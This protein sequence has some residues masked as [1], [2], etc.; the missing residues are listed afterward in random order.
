MSVSFISATRH[1]CRTGRN[2]LRRSSV[3]RSRIRSF[4]ASRGIKMLVVAC[5]TASALALPAI[6]EGRRPR[7][8]RCDRSRRAKGGRDHE[9]RARTAKIA[10]SRPKRR[11]Q[12]NAYFEAIRRASDTAEVV[13]SGCP[14]FVSL[15]EENWTLTSRDRFDRR[16]ISG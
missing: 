1:V 7:C 12:S 4:L 8:R 3:T 15:A 5:N 6:R 11:L 9:N 10:S 16:K 14:L 13:Q 2:R